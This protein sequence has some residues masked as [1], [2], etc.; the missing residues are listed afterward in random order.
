MEQTKPDDSIDKDMI[1]YLRKTFRGVS[2]EILMSVLI[3][4]LTDSQIE[5]IE[6]LREK[7]KR[8]SHGNKKST[9]SQ[10]AKPNQS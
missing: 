8:E 4:E 6:K 2:S 7:K 1:E 10:T 3:E 5:E 9:A